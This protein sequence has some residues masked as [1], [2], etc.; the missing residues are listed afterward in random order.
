[1]LAAGGNDVVARA[2]CRLGDLDA[3]PAV[4]PVMNQVLAMMDYSVGHR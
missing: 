1:M 3:K 4:A 2:Q